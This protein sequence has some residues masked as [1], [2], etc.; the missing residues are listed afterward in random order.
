MGVTIDDD[1]RALSF[2][3]Q[4]SLANYGEALHYFNLMYKLLGGE[5]AKYTDFTKW[6]ATTDLVDVSPSMG[7]IKLVIQ[8]EIR[9]AQ[10]GKQL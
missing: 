1:Q 5:E 3:N 7:E 8:Q 2:K 6:L 4:V 9:K 10:K